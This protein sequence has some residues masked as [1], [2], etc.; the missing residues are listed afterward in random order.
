M[1]PN[2]E[3]ETNNPTAARA[4]TVI[5]DHSVGIWCARMGNAV[6]LSEFIYEI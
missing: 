3:L 5:W 4:D 2:K 6:T 1:V